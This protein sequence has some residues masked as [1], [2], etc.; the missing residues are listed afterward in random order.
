[1]NG[2]GNRGTEDFPIRF[3]IGAGSSTRILTISAREE[4]I[5]DVSMRTWRRNEILGGEDM[6]CER[7]CDGN[8]IVRLSQYL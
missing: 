6:T 2:T 7:S 8:S 3:L 4:G 5:G 1:M